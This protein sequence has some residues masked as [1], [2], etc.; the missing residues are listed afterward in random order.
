LRRL[1]GAVTI[2]QQD[3]HRAAIIAVSHGEVEMAVAVE[4]PHRHGGGRI[5]RVTDRWEETS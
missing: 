5:D 2:A 3:A 4:V 1:E